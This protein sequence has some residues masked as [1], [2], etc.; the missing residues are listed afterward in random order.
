MA[1]DFYYQTKKSY[2]QLIE[3]QGEASKNPLIDTLNFCDK[4]K[5]RW[6][7]A[8]KKNLH[9]VLQSSL[10]ELAKASMKS[11][12]E[13]NI[14]LV[15]TV[16]TDLSDSARLAAKWLNR[17]KGERYHGSGPSFLELEDRSELRK[18]DRAN[19]FVEE[20]SRFDHTG[21]EK[22]PK[23]NIKRSINQSHCLPKVK[24][25]HANA[26]LIADTYKS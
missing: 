26:H 1:Q 25:K 11:A 12:H 17:L 13:N 15:D 3:K 10:A 21:T 14:S 5:Y 6:A 23:E 24:K 9:R 20:N 22:S 8:F 16:Y 19:R 7:I 2:L 4:I 18:I